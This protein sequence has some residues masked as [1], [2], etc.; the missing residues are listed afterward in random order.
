MWFYVTTSLFTH[1]SFIHLFT[2]SLTPLIYSQKPCD[3]FCQYK[4]GKFTGVCD[5]S[6]DRYKKRKVLFLSQ[7]RKGGGSMQFK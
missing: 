6:Y 4:G 5:E 1:S 7:L 3:K 2:Y